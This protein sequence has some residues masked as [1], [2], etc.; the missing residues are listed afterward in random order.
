MGIQLKTKTTVTSH[1]PAKSP[2]PTSSKSTSAARCHDNRM[3]KMP[4]QAEDV[5]LMTA[6]VKQTAS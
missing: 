3:Q 1:E 4:C 2:G 6:Y 5:L